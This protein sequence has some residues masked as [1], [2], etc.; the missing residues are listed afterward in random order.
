MFEYFLPHSSQVSL[1]SAA[2]FSVF[3]SA[4]KVSHELTGELSVCDR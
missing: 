1:F 2:P 3:E 4:E